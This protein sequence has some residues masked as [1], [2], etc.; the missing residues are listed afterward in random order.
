LSRLAGRVYA[1]LAYTSVNEILDQGVIPYLH[2]VQNQCSE[3][4]NT[5]YQLY[6]DYSIQSALTGSSH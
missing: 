3:I 6:I 4:H 2:R 1:S 5:I